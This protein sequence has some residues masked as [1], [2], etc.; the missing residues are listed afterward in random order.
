MDDEHPLAAAIA[1]TRR[2]TGVQGRL[3]RPHE[4]QPHA[5]AMWHPQYDQAVAEWKHRTGYQPASSAAADVLS[6]D[7]PVAHSTIPRAGSTTQTRDLAAS[8]SSEEPWRW[9]AASSVPS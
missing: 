4:R 7:G 9:A 2:R 3:V 1:F 5:E 8:Q 6:A